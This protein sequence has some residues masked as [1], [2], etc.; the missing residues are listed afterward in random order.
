M[1]RFALIGGGGFS[2]EV[3][4]IIALNGNSVAGYFATEEGILKQPYWGPMENINECRGRFDCVA[5][6]FGSVDRKSG[7]NRYQ[8]IEWVRAQH[9][10]CPA[11]ISPYATCSAGVVVADGVF[12]AHGVV[13]S[14]DAQIGSFTILNSGAIIGHDALIGNNVVLAPGAFVGGNTQIGDNS[15]L[16]PGTMTLEGRKIGRSVVVGVGATVVRNVPDGATVMPIRSKVLST[17]V[18]LLA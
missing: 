12:V 17:S 18:S 15:L 8:V 1:K 10:S 16:G 11:V 13:I 9:V 6:G 4:E 3:A 7:V 14:V 2:K 5:I